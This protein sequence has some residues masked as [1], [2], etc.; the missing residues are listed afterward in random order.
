VFGGLVFGK[1]P[2][3]P[4]PGSVHSDSMEMFQLGMTG[5]PADMV[6][7]GSLTPEEV[8]GIFDSLDD[9][10]IAAPYVFMEGAPLPEPPDGK[11]FEVVIPLDGMGIGALTA[12]VGGKLVLT[13]WMP[14]WSEDAR[15]LPG[16][17]KYFEA[18]ELIFGHSNVVPD[19]YPKPL[20]SIVYAPVPEPGSYAY[21]AAGLGL[22]GLLVRRRPG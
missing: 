2:G 16:A 13:G 6:V 9:M 11:G 10:P 8:A 18:S 19:G 5:I 21:F 1:G 22:L 20:L 17:A 12:A 7:S 3:D 15:K 14:S 4:E